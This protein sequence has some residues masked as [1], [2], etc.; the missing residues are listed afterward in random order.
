MAI[1][2]HRPDEVARANAK[3]DKEGSRSGKYHAD[4]R[5]LRGKKS[6]I[7]KNL[8]SFWNNKERQLR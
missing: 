8:G 5:K 2:T 1:I 3:R 6:K 4:V 7:H